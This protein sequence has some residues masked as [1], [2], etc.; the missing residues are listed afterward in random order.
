MQL[1]TRQILTA[2]V[3]FLTMGGPMLAV[4]EKLESGQYAVLAFGGVYKPKPSGF[5]NKGVYGIRG[6]YGVTDRVY[7]SGSLGHSDFGPGDQ[8]TLDVNNGYVFR[9][10]KRVSLALTGGIGYAFFNDLG[11]S[12]DDSFT[13]NVGMGPAIQL[14]DRLAL[15]IL[16][17]FRWYEDRSRDE[18]DQEITIGLLVKLGQ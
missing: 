16:N 10:G 5:N 13:M 2:L 12:V 14:N 11:S 7:V 1:M 8:T 15:R 6:A 9:P 18:V 17:R 3:T 4:A